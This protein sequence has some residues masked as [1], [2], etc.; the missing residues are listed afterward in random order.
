[1]CCA[2]PIV[3]LS[4]N[5]NHIP[6]NLL[7]SPTLPSSPSGNTFLAGVVLGQYELGMADGEDEVGCGAG[8]RPR[9]TGKGRWEGFGYH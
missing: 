6:T 4:L 5:P 2:L 3:G 9:G 7:R 8:A 1:M